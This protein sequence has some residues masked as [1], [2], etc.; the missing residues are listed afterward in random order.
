MIVICIRNANRTGV[1][2]NFTLDDY[3]SGFLMPDGNYV[4]SVSEHKTAAAHGA[5]T[6]ALSESD[7]Q[8]LR[9]Y[10]HMRRTLIKEEQL[11]SST[12]SNEQQKKR[13]VFVTHGGDKMSQSGI[14]LSMRASF[15]QAGV[16]ARIT[17]TGFRKAAVTLVHQ[18]NPDKR[19]D[20]AV[21]MCH[22]TATADR[23]YRHITRQTNSV[24]ASNIIRQALTNMDIDVP[25]PVMTSPVN[26]PETAVS[27]SEHIP[28]TKK[29]LW[30][31]EDA[32][33]VRQ[34]IQEVH[35]MSSHAH[36]RNKG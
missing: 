36:K 4:Y 27:T 26:K 18:E 20:I 13:Y 25:V 8:L 32:D 10:V 19:H 14:S 2:A 22:T 12:K 29:F 7:N 5:A 1:L 16:P 9:Q 21:H 33:E 34:K 6:I 24:K 31:K 3:E 15:E 28:F 11:S 23:H 17:C 35:P 30:D